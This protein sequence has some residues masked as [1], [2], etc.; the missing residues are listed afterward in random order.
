[1]YITSSTNPKIITIAGRNKHSKNNSCPCFLVF[2][3]VATFPW[4][5]MDPFCRVSATCPSFRHLS[6][7]PP[8]VRHS[9]V[10]GNPV[11]TRTP[12]D[13]RLRGNDLC[14]ANGAICVAHGAITHLRVAPYPNNSGTSVCHIS[15]WDPSIAFVRP[16][17]VSIR[18]LRACRIS[19]T[20]N[21]RFDLS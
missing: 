15:K 13:S 8:L 10:G 12:L 14:L 9:R 1:M 18:F 3:F 2:D 17:Q 6:V 21:R 5:N 4:K 19:Q 20:L 7:I 11:I 16:F